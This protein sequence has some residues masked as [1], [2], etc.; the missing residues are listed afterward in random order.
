MKLIRIIS[1]TIVKME[2]NEILSQIS[3]DFVT[4]FSS[5]SDSYSLIC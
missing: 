1:L 3:T 5:F 2:K 4:K